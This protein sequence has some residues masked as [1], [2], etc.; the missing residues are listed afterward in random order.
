[1]ANGISTDIGFNVDS[2]IENT[3]IIVNEL[4]DNAISSWLFF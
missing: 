2:I 1:M 4:L 3:K